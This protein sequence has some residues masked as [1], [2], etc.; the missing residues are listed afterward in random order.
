MAGGPVLLSALPFQPEARRFSGLIASGLT[1]IR[2]S[3][4]H[5]RQD[6]DQGLFS[7]LRSLSSRG[8]RPSLAE[9]ATDQ[10]FFKLQYR[11]SLLPPHWMPARHYSTFSMPP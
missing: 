7:S 10:A 9:T 4:T 8:P 11:Q 2:H 3:L 1:D 5:V 6:P